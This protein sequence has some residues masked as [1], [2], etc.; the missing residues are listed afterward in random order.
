M[1][2]VG[3]AKSHE[4][5]NI[6]IITISAFI[7]AVGISCFLDPNQ[8]A[9]GGITGIAVI[10]NRFVNVETGTLYFWLNVPVVLLGVWKFGVRFMAKTAFAIVMVSVFTNSLNPVGA[11]TDDL[12]IA[13]AVGGILIAVGMGMIFRAGA[14]TGGTDIIIKVLR[15]KY[16]HLKTG[17]LFLVSDVIIVS[18]SGLVFKNLNIVFYALVTVIISGKALDYV[19][20]GGDE[21]KMIYIMTDKD[22]EI[23]RRLMNELEVGV[24][25]LQGRGGWKDIDKMV[26]FTVVPNRLGPEVE[27]IVKT[28]DPAAFMIVGNALEIYGEGYKDFFAEKI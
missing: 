2:E 6:I 16:R 9:P 24:T 5:K 15:Q 20:Y 22:H 19:L 18:I 10:L 12:L 17:F 23:G 25:Y 1:R 4:L 28:E 27:E 26:V 7:Y 13:G 14:T 11:L 3:K 21:A 8:L